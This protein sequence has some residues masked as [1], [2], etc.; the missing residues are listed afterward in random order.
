MVSWSTSE[1][2]YISIANATSNIVPLAANPVFHAQL[3]HV[4]LDLHFVRDKVLNGQLQV[5]H[6]PDS[7]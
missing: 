4:G 3:K 7:D 2:E 5:N 1:A 6:V